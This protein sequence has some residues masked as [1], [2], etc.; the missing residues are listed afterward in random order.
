MGNRT[1]IRMGAVEWSASIPTSKG[2]LHFNFRK[3]TRDERR[4]FHREFMSAYRN[5]NPYRPILK[6]IAA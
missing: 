2:T 1:V 3:M 4:E 5:L 6:K